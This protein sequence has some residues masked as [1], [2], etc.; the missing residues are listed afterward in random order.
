M[1]DFDSEGL[2]DEGRKCHIIEVDGLACRQPCADGDGVCE[3]HAA[4]FK[5]LGACII[6]MEPPF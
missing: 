5:N 2:I 4:Y 6:D 1:D 3:E